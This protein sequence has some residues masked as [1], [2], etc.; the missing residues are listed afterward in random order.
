MSYGPPPTDLEWLVNGVPGGSSAT[1]TISRS[2]LYTAPEQ[3]TSNAVIMV[4]VNSKTE[5]TKASSATVTVL[6][7]PIGAVAVLSITPTSASVPTAGMQLF[8]ASVTGTSNTAVTWGLSGAGCSG[9]SCG[10]LSTSSL[11]A[12]AVYLAPSAAP[13]P[14]SV[15]LIA[16][17]AVD[18]TKSASANLIIVPAPAI[19]VGVT[20]A[21]VSAT[22]GAT[23]QF[24]ASVTGT[25]NTAVNW[26][27][28]GAGC[29]G[30][31]CGTIN[32]S[33]LYTA[34]FAVPSHGTVTATATSVA[35]PTK[36]A[37]AHI[38][39]QPIA[40]ATYYLAT[41]A[42]GGNDSNNGKSAS[43]PW[44]TPNHPVNCGDVILAA[45]STSYSDANFTVGNWGTVACTGAPNVAW[46]KCIAFDA[47]KITASG[48]NPGIYVDS[49]Y[50]GV[51]GWE[52]SMTASSFAGCFYAVPSYKTHV[53][54]HH[55]VFANNVANGCYAGGLGMGISGTAS[56]D[57]VAIVGNIAYNAAAGTYCYSNIN[58]YEP[59]NY[60]TLPG[61]HIYVAGNFSFGALN[62]P[63]CNRGF[64]ASD[65][66]GI[67]IDTLDGSQSSVGPY[68]QQVVVDNNL[69]V[70]NGGRGIE[71]ENNAACTTCAHVYIRHNTMWGDSTDNTQ[72]GNPCA[73][74]QIGHSANNV[75]VY[76][77]ISVS[78]VATSC[79]GQRVYAYQVSLS[80]TTTDHIYNDWGYSPF[81]NNSNISSSTG[82]LFDPN[83]TFGTNPSFA[84]AVIPGAPSC[85]S[86]DSV[87][88]CMA[89]LIANFTPTN[90]A[91][92]GYGYQIPS[93]TAV[94][95]PLFPQWLCN[96]NLPS[97][98][99]TMGCLTGQ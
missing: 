26:T 17:S 12:S 35:D 77:N 15:N 14:A 18:P 61:T 78:N 95:D 66:E 57:Y 27:V 73:E 48:G 52:V 70:D 59:I 74:L 96:V 3:V 62:T 83:N 16:T 79:N 46:L 30:T 41:A 85:G 53:P 68:T 4:A 90:A 67:N 89:T 24:A 87:P 94:Y 11:S 71:V 20:P 82:F 2:G 93:S 65:G 49:S 40:G 45:A 37:S 86:Y 6:S 76:D 1:G 98:L 72:T 55:I 29:S 60:D 19:V 47:C 32:S 80:P 21:N 56:A 42:G 39:I 9:S 33:G 81:G 64:P 84:N 44:L 22:T 25:S 13:S 50:W 97:G 75:E 58:V 36:T 34:P 38:T 8:T 99:V 88:A 69:V 43:S 5:P 63:N 91:A 10:T 7:A 23:Q 51:Q 31:T 28:S 54:V 92:Q